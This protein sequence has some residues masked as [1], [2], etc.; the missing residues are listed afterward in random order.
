MIGWIVVDV[1]FLILSYVPGVPDLF[2]PP[3]LAPLLL[4]FGVWTGYKIVQFHGGF[5]DA[6]IAGGAVGV[7]CGVLIIIGNG[8]IRGAGFAAVWPLAVWAFGMNLFGGVGG[9][10]YALSK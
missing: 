3:T 10:G 1:A 5:V 4:A 7:V 6:L 8:F 2:T 9:G